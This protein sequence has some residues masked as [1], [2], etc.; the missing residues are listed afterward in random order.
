[1]NQLKR[2]TLAAGAAAASLLVLAG[3]ASGV[4]A[5][6]APTVTVTSTVTATPA[7]PA[8]ATPSPDDPL[9][10]LT[11]WTACAVFAQ[12]K[13]G[14]EAPTQKMMPYDPAYPATENAAGNWVAIVAYPVDPPVE[15]TG[16]VI[17]SC[18]IGGTYGNPKLVHW[19]TK[20]I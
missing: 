17:V 16:S 5:S 14:A 3:C 8:A 15:G 12:E 1:M 19:T 9:D 18:G 10:A 11:A 6:P 7:P 4:G 2:M 13:Y 20:D